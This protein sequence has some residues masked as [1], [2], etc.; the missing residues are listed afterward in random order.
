MLGLQAV[1]K[2]NGVCV[3][4]KPQSV[5]SSSRSVQKPCSNCYGKSD[6]FKQF[7]SGSVNVTANCEFSAP[8]TLCLWPSVYVI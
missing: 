2:S 3:D 5:P 8:F 6:V 7:R 4:T 1:Q